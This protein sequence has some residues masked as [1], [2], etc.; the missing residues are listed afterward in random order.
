M[1]KTSYNGKTKEALSSELKTLRTTIATVV[2]KGRAG[3]NLKDYVVA[4][5]NI[6]RVL[7]AMNAL[8]EESTKAEK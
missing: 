3:K 5:K 2:A 8:P 6:A 7:T 1:K 4:R